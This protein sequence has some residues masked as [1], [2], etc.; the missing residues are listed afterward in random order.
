V[1]RVKNGMNYRSLIY[2]KTELGSP[3][4]AV[5]MMLT[6]RHRKRL[7][8]HSAKMVTVQQSLSKTSSMASYR[9]CTHWKPTAHPPG[10]IPSRLSLGYSLWLTC[11]CLPVDV[12]WL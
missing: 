8:V 6:P 4:E 12:A 7:V 5:S 11:Y 9:W 1:V 3:I 2:I 10:V